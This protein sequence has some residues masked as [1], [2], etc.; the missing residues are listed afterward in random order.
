MVYTMYWAEWRLWGDAAFGFHLVNVVLH[1]ANSLLLC[2][3]LRKMR[4]PGAWLAAAIFALHPV[5]VESVAW[6]HERKDVLSALFYIAAF[7][8]FLHFEKRRGWPLLALG[9]LLFAGGLLSKTVVISL[10]LA[11]VIWLWYSHER[12]TLRLLLP[13]LPFL[14]MAI[15]VGTIDTLLARGQESVN[16]EFTLPQRIILAGRAVWFY[17]SK[18]FLPTN[19]MTL[20][21]KWDLESTSL[22]PYLYPLSAVV[23]G[24]VLWRVRGRIGKGPLACSLFYVLTL[25]PILGF[26]DFAFMGHA[27][28]ADRF[29]YLASIGPIVLLAAVGAKS[30]ERHGRGKSHVAAIASAALLV[31]LFALTWR[32]AMIYRNVETLFTHA[33]RQN[34]A[35][36]T[37]HHNLAYALVQ[38][39]DLAN[40]AAHAQ[41]ALRLEPD[42]PV[43]HRSLGVIRGEQGR[44]REAI[45][46]YQQALERGA[47]SPKMINDLAWYLAT[48]SDPTLRDAGEAVRLAEIAN[49]RSFGRHPAI[50]DTLAAAYAESG[51]FPEA[52]ETARKA[53]RLARARDE[54]ALANDI[55]KHL[56]LYRMGRPLRMPP[57]ASHQRSPVGPPGSQRSPRSEDI[58]FSEDQ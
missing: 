20:Y 31:C 34:P 43:A 41:E 35:S 46:H 4:V 14:L 45:H 11:M 2:G 44:I 33:V 37:A 15:G 38:K 12:L 1:A 40:A 49:Q 28:V 22:L 13:V 16:F 19:L 23:L 47:T 7:S 54:K 26:V 55:A 58:R 32:Q 25:A 57:P 24:W 9:L 6:I 18:A 42:S 29:Q 36:G 8:S 3:M 5:H 27:F 30:A 17:A 21:P 50:L 56:A 48:S 39:G 10:P 51:R 53:L 52:L